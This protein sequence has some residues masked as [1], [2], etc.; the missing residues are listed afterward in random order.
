[1]E[2]NRN[3]FLIKQIMTVNQSSEELETIAAQELTDPEK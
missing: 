3:K 1:M 2:K